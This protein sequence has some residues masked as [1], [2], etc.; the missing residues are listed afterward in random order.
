MNCTIYFSGLYFLIYW[1]LT[2]YRKYASLGRGGGGGGLEYLWPPRDACAL[3]KLGGGGGGGG[4]GWGGGGGKQSCYLR[5]YQ[6]SH[7]H[8]KAG[9]KLES[10][11]KTAATQDITLDSKILVEFPTRPQHFMGTFYH[12]KFLTLHH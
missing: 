1:G 10:H 12:F 5:V 9:F 11:S 2:I 8:A 7:C 6:Q 3:G 4:W